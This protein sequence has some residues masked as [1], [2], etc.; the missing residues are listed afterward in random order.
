METASFWRTRS[1]TAWLTVSCLA[2][3]PFA[4]LA[5][6]WTITPRIAGQEIFTDNVLLTP[7]N[8]RSDF[9]TSIFPGITITGESTRLQAKFDYSP[10]LEL[11]ALTPNQ[12][13]IGH[14][15]Y[16]NGNASIV[17]D[18]FFLDARGYMALL[19]TNP[20]LTTGL[21]PATSSVLPSIP[22]AIGPSFI[23]L[24]QG[25]PRNQLSQ[26]SSFTASPYLTHRFDGF[27]TAELRYTVSDTNFSGTQ[28]GGLAP[29]GF[30]VQNTSTL[31]NEA[32]ASFS[33][34]DNFGRFQA[35]LLL[36]AAQ[37][38]G[39]GVFNGSSQ[40]VELIDMGYA[41]TRAITATGTIG[42]EQLRFGGIPATRIDDLVWSV[43]ARVTPS[44]DATLALSYGHR[45]GVTAPS[46]SLIYNLTGRT[47]LSVSYSESISTAA[48]NI[49]NNLSISDVNQFGQTIDSRTGIPLLLSNPVLG[50]QSGV[51]N[52][53][54]LTATATTAWERDQVTALIYHYENAVVGQSTPGSGVSQDT[55][56]ANLTWSRD[57]NPLTTANLGIGYARINLGA[58]TNISEGLLNA[59][60]SVTYLLSSSL[61]GWASYSFLDRSSPQPQFR[62]ASNVITVG[63]RK[64]F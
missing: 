16:A 58:P 15:L 11:F 24:Q 42:H 47:T 9:I 63:L 35:R 4:A 18:L 50:L 49:A 62:V 22:S 23:N 43:G 51:F 3:L 39:T 57:L 17:Q 56:G 19:P 40:T 21:V 54:Q 25:I 52:S 46:A 60:F 53:K 6:D 29:P 20:G 10:T 26:V 44:P 13:F 12:N 2:N 59:G 64:D 14:N 41:V 38:S 5:G 8:R 32:T 61:T 36:D 34:G 28:T 31:T 30:A 1:V 55:T 48:Q 37:S 33:T 45:N 7:A 27:G